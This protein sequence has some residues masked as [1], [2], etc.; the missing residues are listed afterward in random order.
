MESKVE[1]ETLK[2]NTKAMD[3]LKVLK[4]KSRTSQRGFF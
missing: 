2:E 3:D 4:Q 1:S